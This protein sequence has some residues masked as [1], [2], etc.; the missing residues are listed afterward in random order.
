MRLSH[1][2]TLTLLAAVALALLPAAPSGAKIIEIGSAS[3][4]GP[5][6]GPSNPCRAVSRTTGYQAKVGAKRQV[7]TAPADG[8]IVAWTIR[9]GSPGKA[10]IKNFNDNFGRARAGGGP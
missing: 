4:P 8:K 6:P 3:A 7:M 1:K 2:G 9:L 10:H 5:P